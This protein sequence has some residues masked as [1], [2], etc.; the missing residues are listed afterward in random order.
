[1]IFPTPTPQKRKYALFYLQKTMPYHFTLKQNN[2]GGVLQF[3]LLQQVFYPLRCFLDFFTFLQLLYQV[4]H[5]FIF[6]KTIFNI[7]IMR[8]I[9]LILCG[10]LKT[11]A[12]HFTLMRI[13]FLGMLCFPFSF[14]RQ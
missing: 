9:F 8:A 7:A 6:I 11:F 5:L 2:K 3:C 14:A 1:M 13:F 10:T 12:T 4:C